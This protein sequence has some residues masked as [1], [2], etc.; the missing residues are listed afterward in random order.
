VDVLVHLPPDISY[1][2]KRGRV[3]IAREVFLRSIPD[4]ELEREKELEREVEAKS[5]VSDLSLAPGDIVT[6][7]KFGHGTVV[8]TS[9]SGTMAEASINFGEELGTKQLIIYYAPLKKL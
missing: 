5:K 6:H 9:G 2:E 3:A 7:D 8:S 1:K 4:P